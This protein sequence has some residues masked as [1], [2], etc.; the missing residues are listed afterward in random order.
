MG[1]HITDF[2]HHHQSMFIT[3]YLT[4]PLQFVQQ[5]MSPKRLCYIWYLFVLE[6]LL[7]QMFANVYIHLRMLED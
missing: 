5:L 3:K 7:H 1:G 4:F 2:Q 6:V